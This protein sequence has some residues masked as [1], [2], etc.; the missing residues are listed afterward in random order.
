MA[1]TRL[2]G[3]PLADIAGKTMI[4]RVL[5][6]AEEADI[7]EV[8]VATDSEEIGSVVRSAGGKVAMTRSDHISGSDRVAE[9]LDKIDPRG[10]ASF[11]VNLQ[12]DLPTLPPADL[13]T[14][15]EPLYDDEVQI[16]TLAAEMQT[17]FEWESPSV[18]KVV[19]RRVTTNRIEARQFT[20]SVA[21][22]I[23]ESQERL[24]AAMSFG[25]ST[26]A[27]MSPGFLHHI[28][29]YAYKRSALKHFVGL[30]P[31]KRELEE[32][33]EQLRALDNDMRIDAMIVD[34]AP[35]GVDTP[36]DLARVRNEFGSKL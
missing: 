16:A 24:A 20:R 1:S 30:P 26:H 6:C 29:L 25:G 28:G 27:L 32:K 35:F 36:E 9:A 31:S 18:V 5:Q 17:D 11:V 12:G 34:S 13:R 14:V 22:Q 8:W 33:L 4:E 10:S 2:P 15:L 3:K 21:P 23:R 19:G 7:G